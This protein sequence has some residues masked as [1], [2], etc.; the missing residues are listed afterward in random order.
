MHQVREHRESQRRQYELAEKA[1]ELKFRE[2]VVIDDDLGRSGTG[3]ED[4]P[5][6]GKLLTAVCDGQV[7]AVFAL[8][9]SRTRTKQPGLASFD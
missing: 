3:S 4:R 2:V 1:R 6:F 7:G 8:E 5:G 9:A